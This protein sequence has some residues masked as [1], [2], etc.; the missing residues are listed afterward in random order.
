MPGLMHDELWACLAAMDEDVDG[1][2][3]VAVELGTM[4]G[5]SLKAG[6]DLET[7]AAS[8]AV[9]AG[10]GPHREVWQALA[11]VYARWVADLRPEGDE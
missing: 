6:E 3:A 2:R 11:A 10:R 8:V 7:L 1:A 4:Q 5:R 9:R